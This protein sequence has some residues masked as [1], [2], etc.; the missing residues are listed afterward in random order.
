MDAEEKA[1]WSRVLFRGRKVEGGTVHGHMERH[2]K[3]QDVGVLG[4]MSRDHCPWY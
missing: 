1:G 2:K 3:S 4:G